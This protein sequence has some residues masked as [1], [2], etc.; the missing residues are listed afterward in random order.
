MLVVAGI[1]H[2]V[3]GIEHQDGNRPILTFWD[4]FGHYHVIQSRRTEKSEAVTLRYSKG[5]G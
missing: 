5:S 1:E 3:S 2:P 4:G